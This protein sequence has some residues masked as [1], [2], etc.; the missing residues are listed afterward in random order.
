MVPAEGRALPPDV[1]NPG[2]PFIKVEGEAYLYACVA[3]VMGGT[4][5]IVTDKPNVPGSTA[6]ARLG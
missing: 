3:L 1:D 6:T 2:R 4:V 5:E